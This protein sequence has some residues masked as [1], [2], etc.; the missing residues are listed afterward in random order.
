M[1]NNYIKM[2]PLDRGFKYHIKLDSLNITFYVIDGIRM[3]K[4][5]AYRRGAR[6][7]G[8][9]EL[10]AIVPTDGTICG[11]YDT[12]CINCNHCG[13]LDMPGG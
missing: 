2:T 6:V 10:F 7:T 3:S 9:T 8:K 4:S 12:L 1:K 5:E 13:H 11:E